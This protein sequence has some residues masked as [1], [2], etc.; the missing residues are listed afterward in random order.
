MT[1][2]FYEPLFYSYAIMQYVVCIAEIS[3]REG[4]KW[5]DVYIF[6]LSL[7]AHPIR[8]D[9]VFLENIWVSYEILI[10]SS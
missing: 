1:N 8:M 4:K 7:F 2:L 6:V 10:G 5:I 9:D 3:H